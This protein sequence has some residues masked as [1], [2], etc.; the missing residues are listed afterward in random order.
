MS[1]DWNDGHDADS[2]AEDTHMMDDDPVDDDEVSV[3]VL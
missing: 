1:E 3:E 2:R